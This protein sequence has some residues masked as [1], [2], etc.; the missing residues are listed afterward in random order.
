[1]VQDVGSPFPR[2]GQCEALT[3]NTPSK[4]SRRATHRV[5]NPGA[6]VARPRPHTSPAPLRPGG[7]PLPAP[8]LPDAP[9]W[10]RAPLSPP[11]QTRTASSAARSPGASWRA[12]RAM[13]VEREPRRSDGSPQGEEA[14]TGLPPRAPLAQAPRLRTRPPTRSAGR[15]RA[16]EACLGAVPSG[17]CSAGAE[18]PPPARSRVSPRV[19]EKTK[20]RLWNV[21]P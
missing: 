5:T 18:T 1:M 15:G 6:P 21:R 19:L 13:R 12:R 16:P 10:R 7:L 14:A 8:P 9:F 20:I 17:S 11:S 4:L 3:R 2:E